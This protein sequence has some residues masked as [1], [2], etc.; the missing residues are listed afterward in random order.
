MPAPPRVSG[1]LKVRDTPLRYGVRGRTADGELGPFGAAV[2]VLV[3]ASGGT[4]SGIA[5][6]SL[7]ITGRPCATASGSGKTSSSAD[8]SLRVGVR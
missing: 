6:L 4:V 1:Q 3:R 2:E 5:P 7:P 8:Q